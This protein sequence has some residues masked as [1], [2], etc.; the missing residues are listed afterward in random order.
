MIDFWIWFGI[1]WL[2]LFVIDIFICMDEV[3]DAI[4]DFKFIFN[5]KF[6]RHYMILVLFAGA[7]YWFVLRIRD[8]FILN[9][10]KR[11]IRKIC[12]KD[13]VDFNK[14]WRGVKAERKQKQKKDA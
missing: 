8:I 14:I 1:I 10:V 12:E 2:S 11:K 3:E 6:L 13:G 4:Q 7:P 5:E 9:F